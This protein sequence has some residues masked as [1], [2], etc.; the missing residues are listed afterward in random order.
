MSVLTAVASLSQSQRRWASH[1]WGPDRGTRF[2][3]ILSPAISKG[4]FKFKNKRKGRAWERAAGT[5]AS[6]SKGS[7]ALSSPHRPLLLRTAE[8]LPFVRHHR[9]RSG[10]R[11]AGTPKHGLHRHPWMARASWA[12][13]SWLQTAG[14]LVYGECVARWAPRSCAGP[15]RG[16][17]QTGEHS[18]EGQWA[19]SSLRS[20]GG[21]SPGGS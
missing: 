18:R 21:G 2:P 12:M 19:E 20:H 5:Q 6:D 7:K 4:L 9:S 14:R 1:V 8:G 13:T 17:T 3:H 11:R 16:G 15:Q 10:P